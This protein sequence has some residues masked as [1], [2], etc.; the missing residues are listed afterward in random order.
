MFLHMQFACF[1]MLPKPV[2]SYN[3]YS[4]QTPSAFSHLNCHSLVKYLVPVLAEP[5]LIL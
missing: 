1:D 3:M 2:K 5:Y 4:T